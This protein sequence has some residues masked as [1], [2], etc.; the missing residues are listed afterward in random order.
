[1]AERRT[2]GQGLDLLH[3]D[4]YQLLMYGV[5][6]EANAIT[7]LGTTKRKIVYHA[8]SGGRLMYRGESANH[9]LAVLS[10]VKSNFIE[11]ND[12]PANY[13]GAA[14][15]Y[16]R[17]NSTPN[18][19]EFRTTAQVWSDIKP[20]TGDIGG[21]A[22]AISVTASRQ[23]IG[24]TATITHSTAAGYKHIPAGGAAGNFLKWSALGTATW[25]NIVWGDIGSIPSDIVYLTPAQ[26]ITNKTISVNLNTINHSTTNT[27]GELLVN[28]GTRFDR[29]G[30][31]SLKNVLSTGALGLTWASLD[32][33]FIS[34]FSA[35]VRSTTLTGFVVGANTTILATDTILQAFGKTQGQVNDLYDL[36]ALGIYNRPACDALFDN[37]LETLASQQNYVDEFAIFENMRVVVVD[38]SEPS[39]INKIYK[40]NKPGLVWVWSVQQDGTGADLPQEGHT[41]WVGQGAMFA[42]TKWTFNGSTWVQIGGTGFY[43]GG[44]GIEI[45]AGNVINLAQIDGCSILA[46]AANTA[47]YPVGLTASTND[48]VLMRSTNALTFAQIANANVSTTA[49]IAWSKL[50]TGTVNHVVVTNVSTGVLETL[51]TLNV[52]RGG[53]GQA[54]LGQYAVLIGAGA[55]GIVGVTPSTANTFLVSMSSATNPRW[56][57]YTMPTSIAANDVGKFLKAATESDPI[58][59]ATWEAIS[60]TELPARTLATYPVRLSSAANTVTVTAGTHGFNEIVDVMIWRKEGT[61]YRKYEVDFQVIEV[62]SPVT[63]TVTCTSSENWPANSYLVI[64]GFKGTIIGG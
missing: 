57:F 37:P 10:D 32:S 53:T 47:G 29:F 4:I 27:P 20:T 16:M 44:Q 5:A 63:K 22:A 13:T 6:T 52:A 61:T 23:V 33:T 19:L 25:I 51:A 9:T 50:A 55:S 56:S 17:V 42:D 34:D 3:N 46:R 41:T 28:D 49:A 31:G 30:L 24:G 26:T 11:L 1:M 8:E 64:T 2:F 45:A 59:S 58:G 43:T 15:N 62:G 21:D 14:G 18:G 54:T 39:E 48:L 60:F 12:T 38:S 40:A 36:V 7:Y 35:A